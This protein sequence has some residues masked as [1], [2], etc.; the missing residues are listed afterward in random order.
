MYL[1][2]KFMPPLISVP[3]QMMYSNLEKGEGM[4]YQGMLHS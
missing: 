3:P 1:S 4:S 2:H